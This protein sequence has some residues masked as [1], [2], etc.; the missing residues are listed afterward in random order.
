MTKSL[1]QY[2]AALL[3]KCCSSLFIW[4]KQRTLLCALYRRLTG[5]VPFRPIH[6]MMALLR[7]FAQAGINC[8]RRHF[9][10]LFLSLKKTRLAAFFHRRLFRPHAHFHTA[11]TEQTSHAMD[12]KAADLETALHAEA[13]KW[14]LGK[15]IHD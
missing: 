8:V 1:T 10:R 6:D 7:A 11:L 14:P 12:T 3:K 5:S 2:M 9:P 4:L 13:G 15:R